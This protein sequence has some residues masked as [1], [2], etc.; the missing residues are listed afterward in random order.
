MKERLQIGNFSG[1]S[2]LSV[3]QD[4]H[5]KVLAKNLAWILASPA[6][7]A[8]KEASKENK[9]E[10]QLNMTQAISKSKDTIILLFQRPKEKIISMIQQIHALFIAA[11]EPIRPGR[12]FKRNFKINKREHYM[13]LKPCR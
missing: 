7:D 8:V 5:A 11:T 13:N 1:T 3:Y 2:K 12:K 10:R 6:Q 4:F 9:H